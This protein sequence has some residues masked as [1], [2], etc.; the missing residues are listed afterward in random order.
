MIWNREAECMPVRDMRKLQLQRLKAVVKRA[1][2]KDVPE[3]FEQIGITMV[4]GAAA[5][6]DRYHI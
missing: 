3:T 2:E 4:T 1:Y 5:F 6:V